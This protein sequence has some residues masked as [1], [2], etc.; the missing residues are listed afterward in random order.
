MALFRTITRRFNDIS[1][2]SKLR[3][4]I[5]GVSLVGVMIAAIFLVIADVRNARSTVTAEL[6]M[7]YALVVQN[8][9]EALQQNNIAKAQATIDIFKRNS[10][11][12]EAY[13]LTRN[14][15]V[16]AQYRRDGQ[17]NLSADQILN[18]P[19]NT[20]FGVAYVDLFK[21]I[22]VDQQSVGYIYIRSDLHNLQAYIQ[23]YM[24]MMAL[25]L[26][27]T[28]GLSYVLTSFFEK[29]ISNPLVRLSAAIKHISETQ[30][31]YLRVEKTTKDEVGDLVEGFNALLLQIGLQTEKL[32]EANQTQEK[33]IE[34]LSVSQRQTES[35]HLA[36]TQ[37]LARMSHEIRTPIN[38]VLGMVDL[39]LNSNLTA[40]QARLAKIVRSS[41][42]TLLQIINDLLDFSKMEASKLIV[43]NKEYVLREIIEDVTEILG[44]TAFGKNV[45][46]G[47]YVDPRIPPVLFG[48]PFRLRQVLVNLLG[49]AVKFTAKGQVALVVTLEEQDTFGVTLKFDVIDS[50]IGIKEG[51]QEKIFEAFSQADAQTASRYGGTGLGLT[52]S[53]QIV[54]LMDGRL[55][56][57]S[58]EGVGST[59]SFT[60]NQLIKGKQPSIA[61][62]DTFKGWRCLIAE[63]SKISSHGLQAKL[64]DLGLQGTIVDK[65][66]SALEHLRQMHAVGKSY[67]VL[68]LASRL[69]DQDCIE[70]LKTLQSDPLLN[71]TAVVVMSPSNE[72]GMLEEY[73]NTQW[74]PIIG[75][76]LRAKSIIE[77]LQEINTH[78]FTGQQLL[79]VKHSV[80]ESGASDLTAPVKKNG[81]AYTVLIA[82][83]NPV[84]AEV[85]RS[86]VVAA[87]YIADVFSDGQK[88]VHA[89]K[90][91][92]YD[93]V[94]MD[95]Q[96]PEMDGLE[97]TKAIRQYEQSKR[98]HLPP[99]PIIAAT[100]NIVEGIRE[101]Y[102]VGGM[103]DFIIKPFTR[104]QLLNVMQKW[105]NLE[106]AGETAQRTVVAPVMAKTITPE[107]TR[108]NVEIID[109]KVLQQ[110]FDLQP[111]SGQE[112]LNSLLSLYIKDTA[113]SLEQMQHAL[114]QQDTITVQ[115]IAHKV[116]SSSANVGALKLARFAQGIES[117]PDC[118]DIVE[119]M[120]YLKKEYES[121][122]N[123]LEY[124]MRMGLE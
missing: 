100:A 16:F 115:K 35:A 4:I 75:K 17:Q 74:I 65:G 25:I 59:F 7:G 61:A 98:A 118:H 73:I 14:Q 10:N 123:E 39:L 68:F 81:K 57:K 119:K 107:E 70:F 41:G 64:Q 12:V 52:I 103:S 114:E 27:I 78:E 62:P 44:Q 28:G 53:K 94:L 85:T 50:G 42:M 76:P 23:R 38:G 26:V 87:G 92:D 69:A 46:I 51:V 30:K 20:V 116:K 58:K 19:K 111:E 120:A 1:I 43:Q 21:E 104:T 60:I 49:N 31:Y 82:E 86:M 79:S 63:S 83:D 22:R 37:F 67:N 90:S 106:K 72:F 47:S 2:R 121:V 6:D 5:M 124:I 113:K 99:V 77:A 18:T 91:K 110:I 56:V 11:I 122:C 89:F 108:S 109:T 97:A 29:L 96:M 80:T 93:L 8:M 71:N 36:K 105:L 55:S 95:G 45:E 112:F 3:L 117:L 34:K 33:L 15:K 32:S 84:N 66:Y 40:Q 101:E 102:I 48:D 9:T 54:E 13:I 24:S 88:A